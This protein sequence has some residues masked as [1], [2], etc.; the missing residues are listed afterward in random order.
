[1]SLSVLYSSY[2]WVCLLFF[3]SPLFL[4]QSFVLFASQTRMTRTIYTRRLLLHS[5]H[6]LMQI[7]MRSEVV[8]CDS[9]II[10]TNE[11]I[12][13]ILSVPCLPYPI[14]MM[15]SWTRNVDILSTLTATA[16]RCNSCWLDE[17]YMWMNRKNGR[18]IGF[19]I[20]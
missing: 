9:A 6:I 2:S 11:S 19:S 12:Y 7:L 15:Y 8:S 17:D 18:L 14:Y 13:F 1:V 4:T 3:I 16:V 5:N 20:F 10:H